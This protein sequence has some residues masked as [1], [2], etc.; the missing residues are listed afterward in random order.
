MYCKSLEFKD[1]SILKNIKYIDKGSEGGVM[2]CNMENI[3]FPLAIKMHFNYGA[4]TKTYMKLSVEAGI[5]KE[6]S[7][8]PNII[9]LI[10]DFFSRPTEEMVSACISDKE[11]HELMQYNANSEHN[12]YRTS[13]FLMYKKYPS[14]LKKWVIEKRKSCQ[15]ADIIRICYEISCGVLHLQKNGFVHRDLKLNNILIDN[16]GH[17]VIIDFGM[18]VK[19]NSNG[20][21]KVDL[22]G[23]NAE[24]L[25]PEILN[26]EYPGEVNYSKQPSFAL[27]V[28]FHEIVMGFHPFE[29][30]PL[31]S[32]KYGKKPNIHVPLWYSYEMENISNF[33][34][35]ERF[36]KMINNLLLTPVDKR[37]S[38]ENCNNILK[39]LFNQCSNYYIFDLKFKLNSDHI[40]RLKDNDQIFQ[41]YKLFLNK[42]YP[43]VEYF[44][45]KC[46]QFGLGTK[47]YQHE[48][49]FKY[50]QLASLQN[51]ADA[52]FNLG[53]CYLRGRG[54][55]KD[56]I[57]A[58]KYFQLASHQNHADAQFT[59]GICYL[60]G[61]GT[62][63][64][65]I[66]ALNYFCLASHQNHAK[67]QYFVHFYT[68][69]NK[70][71]D[72]TSVI[73]TALIGDSCTGKTKILDRYVYGSYDRDSHSFGFC[74]VVKNLEVDG[75]ATKLVF[76]DVSGV[77]SLP[78]LAF[79]IHGIVFVYDITSKRSFENLSLWI[80]KY[81][82]KYC[83][84]KFLIGNK[85]DSKDAREVSHEEA[86]S[87][88]DEQ[89]M[90][91]FEVSAKENINID[92]TFYEIIS[93][94][95]FEI[96]QSH[97]KTTGV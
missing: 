46:Y 64:D 87:F 51:H 48:Q 19:V 68:S 30:Y 53:I 66:Q 4:S 17:I 37:L 96:F 7:H 9:Y 91:F 58:L 39:E 43:S 61:R 5:L 72:L 13:L 49:A 15:M 73:N 33:S 12:E 45:G 84:I 76:W 25:A 47:R 31:D 59:L 38:L 81:R 89:G 54:T 21:A 55:D 6:I 2:K 93:D 50:F 10:H 56:E 95:K 18:A 90:T 20:M 35:N 32:L 26:F 67:A 80:K 79:S 74:N 85:C 62:D 3:S 94:I 41:F 42:N 75:Q 60:R 34:L 71:E 63:K 1:L 44:I 88:A 36:I 8:H 52:Q 11:V 82:K 69:R 24:H 65:E 27:G 78:V 29:N 28:L 70:D 97:K 14:N 23:G 83:L 22:P 77:Q 16:E 92:D 57:Q 40:S 86:A